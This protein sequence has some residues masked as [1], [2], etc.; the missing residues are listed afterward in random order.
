VFPDGIP[1]VRFCDPEG[2]CGLTPWNDQP[3]FAW[4]G[5]ACRPT[6]DRAYAAIMSAMTGTA[7]ESFDLGVCARFFRRPQTTPDALAAHLRHTAS[8][9]GIRRV[10]LLADSHRREIAALCPDLEII[11]PRCPELAHDL[12]RPKD[13]TRTFIDDWKTLLACPHI[14]APDG[15]TTMLHPARAAGLQIHYPT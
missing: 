8:R 2:D 13:A 9:L 4:D 6:A 3:Y 7:W 1:G 11:L 15:P 12:H 5:A 10:F 14:V